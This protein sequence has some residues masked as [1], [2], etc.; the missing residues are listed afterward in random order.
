M[1]L[2][3]DPGFEA[4]QMLK[5]ATQLK[6]D[7]DLSSA[8][9]KL[10]QAE[11]AIHRSEVDYGI[12]TFL[13]LPMYLQAAGRSDEAIQRLNQLLQEHSE[14]WGREVRF[15]KRGIYP[16]HLDIARGSVYDKLRLVLK[17]D[18]QPEKALPYGVL[19]DTYFE[20]TQLHVLSALEKKWRTAPKGSSWDALQWQEFQYLSECKKRLMPIELNSAKP[21]LKKLK[22]SQALSSLQNYANGLLYDF[23]RTDAEV[24]KDIKSL[25][26]V[27]QTPNPEVG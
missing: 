5:E 2:A 21:L 27:G 9:T 1:S 8:I 14:P 18:N 6:K 26:T 16:M 10:K 11:E 24:I 19:A 3:S 22:C 7:G 13:R 4:S 15:D 17:R 20:R 12:E 23:N 25:L